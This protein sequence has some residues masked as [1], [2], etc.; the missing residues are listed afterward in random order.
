MKLR[1]TA[2]AAAILVVASAASADPLKIRVGWVAG[3][4]DAPLMMFG[5]PGL[6]VH[7]GVSYTL[8]P[9]H[10]QGSPP[11]ITALATGDVD[12][13]GIGFSSLPTGIL[14]A[15]MTD[16]RIIADVF[17][18]G[19]PGA[20]SNEFM[21]SNDSSIHT[22]ADMKGKVAATN[23]AGSAVDMTLRAM[24]RK[25]GLEDK[26]DVTII[27]VAFP[28]MPAML[29]EHKVD[30]IAGTRILTADPAT[31][32]YART[33]FTQRDA[34]GRSEMVLLVAHQAFLEKNRAAVVDYLEDSLREL[35][36]YSDP[37][38][39]DAVVKIFAD[40]TKLPPAAF[41]SWLYVKGQDFYHD[42]NE[43]PDLDA[44]QSNI[45]TITALGFVKAPLDVRQYV[46]LSYVKA[47]AARLK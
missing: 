33:L 26:R 37:A 24:F 5:K 21:V 45:D 28:N 4:S 20:Y 29:K 43:L 8:D 47:A 12:F 6:T 44:L 35:H 10:F 17:Q 27:E 1:T 16:L 36:W 40:F 7:E 30:L 3:N 32:T 22:V 19:G 25:Q 34:I 9:I 11:E 46:D 31:R 18:D 41:A 14:N 42:P 15:G 13:V 23:S 38:N 2:L 39:H